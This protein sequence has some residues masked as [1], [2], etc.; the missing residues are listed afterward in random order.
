MK[1]TKLFKHFMTLLYIGAISLP[2]CFLVVN[3]CRDVFPKL[4]ASF[5]VQH[6]GGT[7][8]TFS[9]DLDYATQKLQFNDFNDTLFTTMDN[10]NYFVYDSEVTNVSEWISENNGSSYTDV[11]QN[12]SSHFIINFSVVRLFDNGIVMDGNKIAP[13][14]FVDF[15]CNFI[16]NMSLIVFLPEVLLCFVNMVRDLIYTFTSKSKEDK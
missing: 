11:I 1:R 12:T 5:S 15:M 4:F 7:S 6:H 2:I 9:N 14:L 3:V 10:F 13:L 8:D 16:I